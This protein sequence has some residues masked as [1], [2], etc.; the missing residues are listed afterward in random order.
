M[1]KKEASPSAANILGPTGLSGKT[2][3]SISAHQHGNVLVIDI[4]YSGG[5]TI[6]KASKGM[7]KVGGST[8]WDSGTVILS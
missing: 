3:T 6:I 5:S 2:V 8:D 4:G 7:V 1:A